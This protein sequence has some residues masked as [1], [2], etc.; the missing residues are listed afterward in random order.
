VQSFDPDG[1]TLRFGGDD[2]FRGIWF[3]DKLSVG[4]YFVSIK[5]G[6]QKTFKKAGE[7]VWT[8]KVETRLC[9]VGIK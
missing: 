2:G 5:Y 9:E 7:P 1:K 6:N 4:K 8:G 3:Y